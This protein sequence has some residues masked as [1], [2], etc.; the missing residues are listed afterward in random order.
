LDTEAIAKF[1]ATEYKDAKKIVEVMVGYHPWVAQA[2]KK[3]IPN[4]EVIV[5]D[6]YQD[7]VYYVRQ[8][9]GL[10]GIKDDIFDP[11]LEIYRG[12]RLIYAIR[13]PEETLPY[14]YDLAAKVC[15]DILIRPLTD[16]DGIFYYPAKDG[17]R[18]VSYERSNF[19]LLKRTT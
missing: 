5:V 19:W 18:Q 14:V 2:V 1:I 12:A 11:N 13:P 7:K 4:T 10:K 17:W 16:V 15:A 8:Q 3:R 6:R 9:P